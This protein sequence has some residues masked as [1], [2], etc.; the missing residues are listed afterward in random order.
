MGRDLHWYAIPTGLNHSDDGGLKI[1]LSLEGYQV[2]TRVVS[3]RMP[4]DEYEEYDVEKCCAK[5]LLFTGQ[6]RENPLVIGSAHVG[7]SYSNPLWWSRWCIYNIICKTKTEFAL[8]FPA[9]PLLYEITLE[10]LKLTEGI[11]EDLGLPTQESE[12]DIAALDESIYVLQF[13]RSSLGIPNTRV[14]YKS[15]E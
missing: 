14:L 3:E 9:T 8:H 6:F 7:H 12:N 10:D 13:I 5:C 1:C 2:V 11:L 15:E 4:Q